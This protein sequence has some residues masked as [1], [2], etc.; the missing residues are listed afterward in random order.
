MT[1]RSTIRCLRVMGLISSLVEE[2]I[3]IHI[4]G[5]ERAGGSPTGLRPDFTGKFE[6]QFE[7]HVQRNTTFTSNAHSCTNVT[8]VYC[9]Q[10]YFYSAVAL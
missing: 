6:D 8:P 4:F 10:G 7:P 5:K 1:L 2:A 3:K 9:N